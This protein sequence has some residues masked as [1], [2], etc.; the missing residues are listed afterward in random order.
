MKILNPVTRH[1]HRSRNCPPRVHGRGHN[2]AP[3]HVRTSQPT[4]LTKHSTPP[5]RKAAGP[6]WMSWPAPGEQR[7]ASVSTGLRGTKTRPRMS[8]R[9]PAVRNAGAGTQGFPGGDE[10]SVCDGAESV[11]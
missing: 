3:G 6:A 7:G 5:R 8:S 2:V 11:V 1:H 4:I 9:E 10:N